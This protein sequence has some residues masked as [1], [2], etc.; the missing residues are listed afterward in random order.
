MASLLC[1]ETRFNIK[2]PFKVSPFNQPIKDPKMSDR[3]YKIFCKTQIRLRKG[4]NHD[5]YS[6]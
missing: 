4:G 2:T 1:A 5:V 3:K 6:G